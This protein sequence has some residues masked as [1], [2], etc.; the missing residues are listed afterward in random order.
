MNT[1]IIQPASILPFEFCNTVV[2]YL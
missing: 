2:H 1:R